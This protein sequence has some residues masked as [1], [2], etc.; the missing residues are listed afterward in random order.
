[1]PSGTQGEAS[2]LAA[3]FAA[4][5]RKEMHDRKWSIAQVAAG[6]GMSKSYTDVRINGERGF[7]VRDFEAFA[8]MVDLEPEE[9][10]VR[11]QLPAAAGYQGRLVPSYE[12]TTTKGDVL[13]RRIE[14]ADPPM[15]DDNIVRGKFG[16]RPSSED[17]L[18]EVAAESDVAHEEDTDDY[19]P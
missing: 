13:V 5:V 3:D 7:T 2:G 1:M 11:V 18:R 10:L 16:V 6:I 12:V 17:A 9:L 19:T 14:D 4:Y 8:R 15:R